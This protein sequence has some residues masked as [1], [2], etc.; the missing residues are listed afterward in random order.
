M[1]PRQELEEPDGEDSE[2][3][4]RWR[5]RRRGRGRASSRSGFRR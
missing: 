4:E 1:R 5:R 3:P 2:H